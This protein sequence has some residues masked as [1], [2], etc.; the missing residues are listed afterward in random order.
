MTNSDSFVVAGIDVS[1]AFLDVAVIGGSIRPSRFANT[2]EGQGELAQ[3]LS[4]LGCA[5]T[6]MEPTGGYEAAAACVLQLRELPVAVV[7]ARRV[8][9]FAQAMGY[10]AKT[11][12]VD[13]QVLAEL[14]SV[15]VRKPDV[16]K[17]LLPIKD[18]SRK[19][20]EA[21]MTRRNQLIAMRVAEENR[22]ELAPARVKPSIKSMLEA[23][24][25]LLDQ[26]DID[27][28]GQIGGHFQDLDQLL[29]SIPGIGPVTSRILIGAL[30]E[31]GHLDRRA[32]S[33]LVG[34]APM[35]KDSGSSQGKRRIQGG[36]AIIRTTLYMATVAASTHNPVIKE[37]YQR[38]RA[39]GK[40]ARVVLVACM[41]KL[42]V[43]LNA[44]VR[45]NTHW[46]M[47]PIAVLP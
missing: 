40:P 14:A 38:L 36:R 25:K 6:V 34:L 35:A 43:I 42:V 10:L 47:V 31:L 18:N 19:E 24:Q 15:L 29:Q 16:K 28:Q 45:T 3:V 39:T 37:F 27:L 44:M 20:L 2:P 11:D 1:K 8:R 5:L 13:A 22:L 33:A 17:F 26:N 41:H 46:R 7:N 4:S 12:S 32:I 21:L 30:P 23:I 9:A